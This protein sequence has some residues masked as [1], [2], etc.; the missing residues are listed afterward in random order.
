[1]NILFRADSSSIIGTGHIVRDLVLAKREFKDDN[2]IFAVQNLEGNINNKIIEAGHK[3][4]LL[5]SNDIKEL[6]EVIKKYNIDMIVIDHYD[7]DNK[8]EKQ[9][10]ILNPQLSIMVLDDTYEKHY[11][12]ILLNHNI[13]AD[14]K[15]YKGLVP[16]YCE[17]R[18]GKKY[19]LLREEFIKEKAIKREKIYDIFIA[20]GGADTKNLNIQLLEIIPS[21]FKIALVTTTANTNLKE[22][23]SYTK[24]KSYVKLYINSNKIAKLINQS[25][26]AIITPSVVANE[27][28]FM[29]LPF[30]AIKTANNQDEMYRYLLK[31]NHKV[32]DKFEQEKI[33]KLSV[34]LI[35]FIDLS[36]DEKVEILSWRNHPYI[37]KWMFDKEIISLEDHLFYIDLLKE[38]KDRVYFAVKQYGQ[39]VGVISFTSI[40]LKNLKAEIGLYAKPTLKGVGKLLMQ[41]ILEYGF[42]KLKLKKLVSK[43]FEDNF[44]AIKLYK[45][46]NFEKVDK[47]NSLIIMELKNEN[48]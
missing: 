30:L 40:D 38:K 12:D 31:H 6:D 8:Y 20:M 43:V 44:S 21:Y 26:F 10:S 3:I 36:Y 24:E 32:V 9:L 39:F 23:Q 17:L 5:K 27:I 2:I 28:F 48:R 33:K 29:G 1:M 18:C 41:N 7:I 42:D 22:L 13:Y 16:K 34:E 19:T 4:E 11:C 14:E 25:K 45:K 47:N 35:N 46:F 37:R 15:R